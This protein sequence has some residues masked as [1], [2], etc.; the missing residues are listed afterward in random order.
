LEIVGNAQGLGSKKALV[1]LELAGVAKGEE[2][3]NA[4][5]VDKHAAYEGNRTG[6]LIVQSGA[7]SSSAAHSVR[8]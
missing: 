3:S 6:S 4:G 5:D 7:T 1:D 8:Q 2:V